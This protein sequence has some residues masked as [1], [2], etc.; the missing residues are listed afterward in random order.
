MSDLSVFEYENQSVR[1]ISIDGEPW[2][3]LSDS[4]NAMRTKTTI[5]AAKALIEEELGDDFVSNQP[6]ED[7]IGR[8]QQ[9]CFVSESGLTFLLGRSRTEAGK[10]FNRWVHGEVLP[11][12]RKTGSYSLKKQS[13]DRLLLQAIEVIDLIFANVPIKPELV[14]GLKLNA[15]TSINP[16]LKPHIEPSRQLLIDCTAQEFNLLTA[17]EIGEKIGLSGQAI[18]KKLIE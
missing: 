8:T 11:S 7:S 5:T 13:E 9:V 14:A 18:N 1:S 4:L 12:I 15:A 10:K 3:C 6:I 17:T 16:A 2:F